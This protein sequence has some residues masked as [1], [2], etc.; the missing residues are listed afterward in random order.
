MT[1]K[2]ALLALLLPTL[3]LARGTRVEF[4]PQSPSTGPFPSDFL[5]SPDSRQITGL[6]VN[7]P[8]NPF[9]TRPIDATLNQLDGF[10]LNTRLTVKFSA[11]IRPDTLRSGI[12]FLWL[13]PIQSDRY[14]LR[15]AGHLTPINEV[16]YDATTNTV[17]AKPDE[18]FQ[19]ARRYAILVTDAVLDA[20]GDPIEEDPGFRACLDRTLGG[21]YCVRLSEAITRYGGALP[22]SRRLVGASIF[23]TLSATAFL[24]RARDVVLRTAPRFTRSP[25]GILSIADINAGFLRTDIGGRRTVDVPFPASLSILPASGVR[26]VSVATFRVPRF[27]DSQGLIPDTPTAQEP[28]PLDEEEIEATI[29]LPSTP[30]PAGGFPVLVAGHGF[31]DM[32]YGFPTALAIGQVSAGYAIVSINAFGH[33][34]GPNTKLVLT[35]ASGE[36]I[37]I[38]ARGRGFDLN[39]DGRIDSGE[40]CIQSS[41]GNLVLT[42]DCLRQ[43]AADLMQLLRV[44][45]EGVDLDGDARPELN[46]AQ[47]FYIGQSLGAFYGTLLHAVEP[48]LRAATLN[49]GGGSAVPTFVY[50][51]E[52]RADI[53]DL[54]TS[55]GLFAPG[56]SGAGLPLRYEEVRIVDGARLAA[57]QDFIALMEWAESPGAP[58]SFAPH[59]NS[60]TLP[61]VPVKRTLFQIARGD[62][63][64]NN[65]S[66]SL[67]IRAANM[68]ESTSV[69]RHDLAVAQVPSLAGNPHTYLA[70]IGP[71]AATVIGFAAQGEAVAFMTS[72]DEVIPDVNPFVALFFRN[73]IFE[74]PKA[75]YEDLGYT[76]R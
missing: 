31:G 4:D 68:L 2:S 21:D 17:H 5:T 6:R 12:F 37:E 9:F 47:V 3:L 1:P 36:R 39:A 15:P 8:A 42:R 38:P 27:A 60:A 46:G 51:G 55:L 52:R 18:P 19:G 61:G 48:Q 20:S 41:P 30:M 13:D 34:Y 11:P 7:L 64:V 72:P 76:P 43:T 56:V 24:E 26:R 66:N 45:R 35:R 28:T 74:R 44:L 62:Q 33:G 58:L 63:T 29:Y 50:G 69:Y 75:Y 53:Q 73:P 14:Q 59:L 25:Q 32:R 10:S 22:P 70:G 54:L 49:V 67:L 65:P 23:T 71:L 57:Y 40:G 16:V